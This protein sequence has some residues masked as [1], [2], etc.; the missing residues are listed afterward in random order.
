MSVRF[1]FN[2]GEKA[3]GLEIIKGKIINYKNK[4]FPIYLSISALT[5]R[6]ANMLL[7]DVFHERG[8]INKEDG[9]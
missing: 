1:K 9:L 5:L 8:L 4:K 3:D 2:Y 7:D 6:T